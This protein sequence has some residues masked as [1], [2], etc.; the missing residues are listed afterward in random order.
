M[1]H[2]VAQRV[3]ELGLDPGPALTPSAELLLPSHTA[4]RRPSQVWGPW[5]LPVLCAL[6]IHT[7][8]SLS[9]YILIIGVTSRIKELY[10]W[11]F[12]V[13]ISLRQL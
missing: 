3:A 2:P 11:T 8:S 13:D 12:L 9:F 10:L 7:P 1:V 4:C 6:N 5:L